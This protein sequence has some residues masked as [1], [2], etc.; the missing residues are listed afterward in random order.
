MVKDIVHGCRFAPK[1]HALTLCT[2]AL[3]NP[4]YRVLYPVL[5]S[6]KRLEK[7]SR[8]VKSRR[9]VVWDHPWQDEL[10]RV[11]VTATATGE[12]DEAA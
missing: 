8:F 10:N 4:G 5:G 3:Q 7:V 2:L 9:A 11:E 6:W 12:E 1:A